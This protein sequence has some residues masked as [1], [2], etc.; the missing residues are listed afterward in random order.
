[1]YK[2]I[3]QQVRANIARPK[4]RREFR[5][6]DFESLHSF[7]LLIFCV[8]LGIWMGNYTD[9]PTHLHSA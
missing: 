7:C 6:H 5:Q 2:N 3:E 4:L 9:L 8:S 1:M